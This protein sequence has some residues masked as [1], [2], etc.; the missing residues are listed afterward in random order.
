[1]TDALIVIDMLND[2]VTGKIAAERAEQIISP[3]DRLTAAAR[4]NGV[5][6]IYANDAHRPEDFEL[7]VWGEHAMQ[8][9]EGAAVIPE[10]EPD[11]GDHVFEKRTYDAFYGTAL[12]EHLRSLGV[13]RVVLTGLHTNMCVRH[14]SAGAFFR[15]YD[16]VIP[17]DCVEAF[18]EEAHTEGLEYLADVYNAEITTADDLIE[19]WKKTAAAETVS[20][21]GTAS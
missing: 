2:F 6:V 15:G 5:P 4:E 12:D 3:L 19:K 1:M 18:S 17:G 14:A 8:G 11:E 9:T 21:E 10:L 20:D 13:D 16:I 7:D